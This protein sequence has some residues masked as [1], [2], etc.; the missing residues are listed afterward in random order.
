MKKEDILFWKNKRVLIT[1]HTGFVGTWMC[2]VLQ[3]YGADIYGL[4][5][6]ADTDSLFE[7]VK[8]DLQ[9]KNYYVD[10]R[11]YESVTKVFNEVEPEIVIHLAAFGFVKECVN[12]PFK[13]Y[14]TNVLG[15]VNLLEAI[16]CCGAIKNVLVVSSDKVYKN[17]GILT[18]YMFSEIDSLGG[19][20]TYSASKT[21]EDLVA[22]S[23]FDTYLKSKNINLNIV[24]PGNILGGAD[25]IQSRLIPSLLN[26]FDNG[27]PIEIRNKSAVRPWQHILDA[28]DAYLTIIVNSFNDNGKM[29]IYNVGPEADGQM[30]VGQIFEYLQDKFAD[31]NT[32]FE[33]KVESDVNEVGYLGISIEK[34]KDEFLWKPHKTIRDILDDVFEFYIDSKKKPVYDICIEQIER[35][36]DCL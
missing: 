12:E 9:I 19:L 36:I 20:D 25:H 5:L 11:E 3:R 21:C 30:S 14:T 15:T 1:G 24:R 16:K 6:E 33:E 35:Y 7:K 17:D 23:Y 28:I 8:K 34:M 10:L 26:G 4:S 22:Q 18:N 29:D 13:T 32:I 2:I 31:C 27:K